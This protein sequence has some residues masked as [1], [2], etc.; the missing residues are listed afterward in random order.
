MLKSITMIKSLRC[1]ERLWCC[2]I[3]LLVS[4]CLLKCEAADNDAAPR[5]AHRWDLVDPVGKKCLLRSDSKVDQSD[6]VTCKYASAAIRMEYMIHKSAKYS[7][8]QIFRKECEERYEPGTEP[9]RGTISPEKDHTIPMSLSPEVDDNDIVTASLELLP[10][11][12]YFAPSW[13]QR[14]TG[15]EKQQH[16]VDF[17]IRM[18]LWTAPEEG[19]V[20]VNFRET[21]VMINLN[22]TTSDSADGGNVVVDSFELE[23]KELRSVTVTFNG[24]TQG[25]VEG[26]KEDEGSMSTDKSDEL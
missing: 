5:P 23:Y 25:A 20:E 1:R 18:S 4:A 12:D 19:N 21:D 13:F 16:T 6:G 26:R 14:F 2:F 22:T 11:K 7:K 9:V 10:N 15:T 24:M 17:C 3:V 8:Y